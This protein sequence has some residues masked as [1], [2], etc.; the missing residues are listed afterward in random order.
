MP[1]LIATL[2]RSVFGRPPELLCR[3]AIWNNGVVELRKRAGGNRE[4]GAFLLGSK[5][6]TRRIEE[7]VFYDDID[8][9]S[10]KSGIVLIDGRRLGDL[11]SHCRRTGYEVVA[12]VHVHRGAYHQ[13]KSDQANPIMA[14]IGHIAI[15][16]PHYAMRA[17]QPGGIGVFEYLGNRRWRD[18]SRERPSPLHVGWWPRWR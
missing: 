1:S 9:N 10:L 16:F 17:M 11:W 13:S 4:S 6:K 18:R 15:I 3:R 7:F 12:D 5:G 8:P 2:A 14:E